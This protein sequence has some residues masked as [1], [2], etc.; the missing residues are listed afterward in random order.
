MHYYRMVYTIANESQCYIA[1]AVCRSRL[2]ASPAAK[3][4]VQ[5]SS[6]VAEARRKRKTSSTH[7]RICSTLSQTKY[8]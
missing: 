2:A 5:L 7:N 6:P 8:G 4:T 1:P 3:G